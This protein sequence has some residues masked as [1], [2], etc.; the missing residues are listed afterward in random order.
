M[1]IDRKKCSWCDD[2]VSDP[3]K[4]CGRPWTSP[5]KQGHGATT[6]IPVDEMMATRVGFRLTTYRSWYDESEGK[7]Q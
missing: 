5:L 1:I 4:F 2:S 6:P 7:K 3:C